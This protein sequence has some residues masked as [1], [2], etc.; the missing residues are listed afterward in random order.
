MGDSFQLLECFVLIYLF[1]VV[2]ARHID[3]ALDTKPPATLAVCCGFG[4]FDGNDRSG[5]C[6]CGC[7]TASHSVGNVPSSNNTK[8]K[9][10]ERHFHVT[11]KKQ[12]QNKTN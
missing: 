2:N 1:P 5:G 11:R 12:Q 9:D 7:D 8:S 4:E 3:T 10:H 6:C